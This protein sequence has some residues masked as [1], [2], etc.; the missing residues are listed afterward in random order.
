MAVMFRIF[1]AAAL[2]LIC[3][4]S[5]LAAADTTV[6]FQHRDWRVQHEYFD[7]TGVQAC[8]GNT[9]NR[10]RDSFDVV[11]WE[12]GAV[13]LLFYMAPD[14]DTWRGEFVADARVDI[15]Y[16][17]WSLYDAQ[18]KPYS[19]SFTFSSGNQTVKFL[20]QLYKGSAVA[21]KSA[22]GR[23]TLAV[24]SLKGSAAALL[25]LTECRDLIMRPNGSG[26]R[27]VRN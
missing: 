17:R 2:A 9:A 5:G 14:F 22:D 15:D 18:F 21:L 20:K 6:L 11:A 8:T 24:W 1:T 12:N 23:R 19:I 26:Y 13:T 4:A 25:K 7:S 3:G 16:N 27:A 10:H